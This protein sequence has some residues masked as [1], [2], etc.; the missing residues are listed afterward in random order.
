[1]KS[2]GFRQLT[3]LSSAKGL[4]DG[5]SGLATVA[6]LAGGTG[7][8]V[9]NLLSLAI[10]SGVLM[11]GARSSTGQVR[12]SSVSAGGVVTAVT[13][14]RKGAYT[15]TPGTTPETT[16]TGAGTGC[17]LTVTWTT[18]FVPQDATSALLTAE[19]KDIRWR[20]DGV[21]PSAT[22]GNL[23][24]VGGPPFRFDGN[25]AAFR[26]FETSASGI[27]NCEFQS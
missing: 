15:T 4:G 2:E 5:V 25:L 22:V 10:A 9:G 23:L 19:A 12:V 7:Y 3:G 27:L 16:T 6:V 18:P 24:V 11:P 21:N 1:M 14:E 20:A 8:A 26:A 13:L 17:T